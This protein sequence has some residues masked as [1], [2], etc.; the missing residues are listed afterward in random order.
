VY[1]CC[2]NRRVRQSF[3]GQHS[4]ELISF[5]RQM[6]NS[7]TLLNVDFWQR[8][9]IDGLVDAKVSSWPATHM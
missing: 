6:L 5:P 8:D 7:S 1:I 9:L 3:S 4:Q 2:K